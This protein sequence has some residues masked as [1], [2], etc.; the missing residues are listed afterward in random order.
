[1]SVDERER[2]VVGGQARGDR[3]ALVARRAERLLELHAAPVRRRLEERDH[4]VVRRLRRR[5]G[6]E[7]HVARCSHERRRTWVRR[8][9]DAPGA[10]AVGLAAADV[11]AALGAPE[12][13]DAA[14]DGVAAA[15]DGLGVAPVLLHALT[16]THARNEKRRGAA[17]SGIGRAETSYPFRSC[18]PSYSVRWGD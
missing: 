8:V 6:D 2:D 13:A 17:A 11:A 4:R 15:V 16:R 12:A 3:A 18:L 1:M 10:A 7:R 14:V 5:V 9:L